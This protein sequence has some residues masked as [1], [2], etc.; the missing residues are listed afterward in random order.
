MTLQKDTTSCAK[1]VQ[2]GRTREAP[3]L[4]V[5][6]LAFESPVDSGADQ[7]QAE[8]RDPAARIAQ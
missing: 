3:L 2:K 8:D 4:L 7:A 1:T 6:C 5:V